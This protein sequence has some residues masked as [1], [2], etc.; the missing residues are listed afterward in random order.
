ME[1]RRA[2][3]ENDEVINLVMAPA[4]WVP[5]TGQECIPAPIGGGIEIGAKRQPDGSWELPL[6]VVPDA[7][8]SVVSRFQARAALYQAGLLDQAEAAVAEGDALVK[9]AWADAREFRRHSPT[10]VAIA[11][12]LGLTNE[13]VDDLFR[14][15]ALIEA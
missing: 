6:E 15:A 9:M 5:P 1:E 10:V 3:V 2:I 7:V 4:D 12:A 14:D 11:D 13:Q 8:P